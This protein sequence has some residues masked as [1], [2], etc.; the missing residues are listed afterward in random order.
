MF[1]TAPRPSQHA[2]QHRREI[3]DPAIARVPDRPVVVD[4]TV[5]FAFDMSWEELFWLIE[6]H[7]VQCW[8]SA[9]PRRGADGRLPA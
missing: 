2:G 9:A 3:F 8:T 5:S 7:T 1:R 6:G 4:N